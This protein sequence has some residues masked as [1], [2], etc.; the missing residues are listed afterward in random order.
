M[1]TQEVMSSA[2][3]RSW[4]WLFV[5][6]IFFILMGSIGLG[7]VVGVTLASMFFLGIL[8]LI[9]GISQI[10]D[11]FKSRRWKGVFMHALIAILYVIGGG[12]VLYD[13]FLA[14]SLITAALGGVLIVIGLMR[15]IMSALFRKVKGWFWL[16]L[17][18]IA[19]LVL[20]ILILT[21]W[22]LSGL[23]FIGLLI[24]IELLICGWT[25]VFFA[26]SLREI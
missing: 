4:G 23:W 1:N 25:Y 20:G 13:P 16:L 17:A 22:P 21:Q 10:L 2:F 5:L 19:A 11:V 12:L 24:S 6:G 7:M 18:G 3:K 14:S 8:L 9:A 15:I 26:F